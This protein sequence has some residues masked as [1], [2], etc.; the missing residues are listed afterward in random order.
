M[1]SAPIRR[2]L[3]ITFAVLSFAVI[4]Q[5]CFAGAPGVTSTEILIGS[6]SALDGP[7]RM[8]GLQTVLG[9]SAYIDMV[10]EEGGVFGR[11]IRLTPYDDS[12]DPE[13]APGCFARLQ[14][15]KVF[16]AGFFVGTPTA[17]KYVPMAEESKLPVVGLFAG[18]QLLYEPVR[19]YVWNVRASYYD[20][21]REQMD[22]LWELGIHKIAV[23][24]PDDAFG[25]AVVEGVKIA[26]KSHGAAPLAVASFKRQT[27]EVDGAMSVVSAAKPQAVVLVGPYAPV[28][29]IVKRARTRGWRP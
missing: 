23:I 15:D 19:R 11:K 14:K 1:L 4:P 16:A 3:S 7:S 25:A 17:A 22:R 12:Y 21:T 5:M 8:L 26:L 10:N 13:K 2:F 27:L 18:A 24:H 29:E 6:C 20:E 28:A 9:A